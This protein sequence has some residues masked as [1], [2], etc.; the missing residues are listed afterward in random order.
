[1]KSP[2]LDYS[3]R[4]CSVF[5]LDPL[6]AMPN[7]VGFFQCGCGYQYPESLGAYGCPNCEGEHMG[8]PAAHGMASCG[9]GESES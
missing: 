6:G 2:K 4:G 8:H 7:D 9:G 3:G 1:M 5:H